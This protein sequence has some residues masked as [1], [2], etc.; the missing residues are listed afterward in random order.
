MKQTRYLPVTVI[1]L[2][3][4]SATYVFAQE[5]RAMTIIDFLEIPELQDPQ[6]SPNGEQLIYV[7]GESDWKRNKIIRHVWRVNMDGT[8]PFQITNGA[9]GEE[10]PRWSPD[11]ARIAF[12]SMFRSP[13]GIY[14][15]DADGD[16]L[17][18]VVKGL[19]PAWSPDGTEIAYFGASSD[20]TGVV[21]TD[22]DSA[23]PPRFIIQNGTFPCWSPDGTQIVYTYRLVGIDPTH[24]SDIF[25][26]STD[27]SNNVKLTRRS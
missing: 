4:A 13:Y 27:G 21:I 1:F 6:L 16:N 7:L 18:Y 11:G 25:I 12:Y 14:V 20:S 26:M 22:V 3:I 8:G 10:N 5:K 24:N 17:K 23:E 15:V 2:L 9:D 19:E